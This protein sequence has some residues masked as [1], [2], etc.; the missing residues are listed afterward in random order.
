MSH[1]PYT[2]GKWQFWCSYVISPW[3]VLLEAITY[4]NLYG[5]QLLE[6]FLVHKR[7]SGNDND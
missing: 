5:I 7:E 3:M 1:D 4:I 2:H 6:M